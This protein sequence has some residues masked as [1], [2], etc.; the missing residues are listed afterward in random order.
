MNADTI[1]QL[2]RYALIAVR[3]WITSKGYLSGEDWET[4]I[5]AIGM[6]FPIIWGLFVKSG[7][8]AV[9]QAVAEHSDI[10]TVSGVTSAFS[11]ASFVASMRPRPRCWPSLIMLA[12]RTT[13][14]RTFLALSS[15]LTALGCEQDIA[16]ANAVAED[17]AREHAVHPDNDDAFDKDFIGLTYDGRTGFAFL[18]VV[19]TSVATRRRT[20][21][22]KS[23]GLSIGA[24]GTRKTKE[25]A[26]IHNRKYKRLCTGN[27]CNRKRRPGLGF[28]ISHQPWRHHSRRDMEAVPAGSFALCSNR[29]VQKG[30]RYR[31][32][33]L[34]LDFGET[35]AAV[36]TKIHEVE[37]WARDNFM[38]RDGFRKVQEQLTAEI[39]GVRDEMKSDLRRIEE[40]IDTKT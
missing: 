37:I 18:Y 34:K 1:W 39:I 15:Q 30:S 36:R 40:K 16:Y 3:G 24:L 17:A 6:L 27:K 21:S 8:K 5:G 10:P 38:R 12:I 13:S 11:S 14:A 31:I 26:D 2:I 29:E 22:A 32:E 7:T 25:Q 19:L 33:V 23:R 20:P 28:G 9:P 35:N 4:L